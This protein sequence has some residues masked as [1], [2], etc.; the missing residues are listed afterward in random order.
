MANPFSSESRKKFGKAGGIPPFVGVLAVLGASY[1]LSS[2]VPAILGAGAFLLTRKKKQVEDRP[3]KMTKE[4]A[5]AEIKASGKD[6]F[7]GAFK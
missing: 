2:P 3:E 6:P 7:K 4:E 1:V 5:V